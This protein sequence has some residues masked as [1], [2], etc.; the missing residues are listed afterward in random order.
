MSP[1][2]V[3]PAPTYCPRGRP[4]GAAGEAVPAVGAAGPSCPGAGRGRLRGSSSGPHPRSDSEL[5]LLPAGRDWDEPTQSQKRA[6]LLSQPPGREFVSPAACVPATG[7]VPTVPSPSHPPPGHVDPCPSPSVAHPL[8]GQPRHPGCRLP[9]PH[10]APAPASLAQG[11]GG[12]QGA[13]TS[14]AQGLRG[15]S[16]GPRQPRSLLR[17]P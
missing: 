15:G 2:E 17:L 9:Q 6:V 8:A 14:L 7:P 5:A 11:L 12:A 4:V 16:G 1:L 10:L 3:C 13:P